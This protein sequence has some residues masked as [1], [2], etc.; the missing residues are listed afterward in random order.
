MIHIQNMFLVNNYH[1]KHGQ[2]KTIKGVQGNNRLYPGKMF[3]EP[4]QMS[5]N[6]GDNA[7]YR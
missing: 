5:F 7:G 6:N 3:I 1:G 4:E 2:D